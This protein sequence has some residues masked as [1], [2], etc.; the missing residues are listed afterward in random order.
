VRSSKN[1][2]IY[3]WNICDNDS[4]QKNKAVQPV[5]A[6]IQSSNEECGSRKGGHTSDNVNEMINFLGNWSLTPL[7]VPSTALVEKKAK[8]LVSNGLSFVNW[9]LLDCGSDS[10]VNDE[11][12]I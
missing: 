6:H 12:S 5:I 8:F 4:Y 1:K 11:L 7:A 3:L 10:P 9:A 2:Y